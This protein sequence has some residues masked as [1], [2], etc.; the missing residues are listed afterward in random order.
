MS[1]GT[2]ARHVDALVPPDRNIQ[3]EDLKD[4]QQRGWAGM[5]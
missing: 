2:V 4:L 1:N 5:H 3:N